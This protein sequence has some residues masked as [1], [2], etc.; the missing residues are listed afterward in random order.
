MLYALNVKHLNEFEPA[1]TR[2][3]RTLFVPNYLATVKKL[4][5][6]FV[7]HYYIVFARSAFKAI[8]RFVYT[9]SNICM[10]LAALGIRNALWSVESS[11]QVPIFEISLNAALLNTL[12]GNIMHGLT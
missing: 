12:Y 1:T 5:L 11:I 4:I 10:D 2:T 3:A 9:F 7:L 8:W 6:I